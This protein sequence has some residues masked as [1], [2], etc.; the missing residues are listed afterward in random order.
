MAAATHGRCGTCHQR[1]PSHSRGCTGHPCR[2]EAEA[3]RGARS[4]CANK[5]MARRRPSEAAVR[6][7]GA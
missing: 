7:P 5:V 3:C 4:S 1:A 2:V 6:S